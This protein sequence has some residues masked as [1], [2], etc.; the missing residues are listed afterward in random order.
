MPMHFTR[1]Y[2]L[3][4]SAAFAWFCRLWS[5]IV[6]YY[7]EIFRISGESRK[8]WDIFHLTNTYLGPR[9][10]HPGVS[11]GPLHIF[12]DLMLQQP[13]LTPVPPIGSG[14]LVK[15][16]LPFRYII[17]VLRTVLILALSLIYVV[18]VRGVCSA[19]VSLNVFPKSPSAH[20]TSFLY[21][22]YTE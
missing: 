3:I 21:H 14:L 9:D 11:R 18:L 7:G 5:S 1:R 20:E 19:L 13:F 12:V 10:R 15:I 6:E 8:L 17:G 2:H 16:A 4:G 22:H